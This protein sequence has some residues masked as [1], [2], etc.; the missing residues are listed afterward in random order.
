MKINKVDKSVSSKISFTVIGGVVTIL[1]IGLII[2]LFQSEKVK[3]KEASET[4]YELSN[5]M[6]ESTASLIEA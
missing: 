1:S 4:V 2:F 3:L 5:E 6:D